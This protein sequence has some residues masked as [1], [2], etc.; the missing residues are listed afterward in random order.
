VAYRT[1][2]KLPLGRLEEVT[3]QES[4][5]VFR[6]LLWNDF[7]SDGLSDAGGNVETTQHN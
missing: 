4:Q 6:K 2:L 7:K 5:L 3:V 1:G